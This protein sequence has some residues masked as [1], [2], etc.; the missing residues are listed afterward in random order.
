MPRPIP[1]PARRPVR[2]GALPT[3]RGLSPEQVAE[4]QLRRIVAMGASVRESAWEAA[5]VQL[6]GIRHERRTAGQVRA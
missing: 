5:Q 4:H 1:S 3:T 6:A 2:V